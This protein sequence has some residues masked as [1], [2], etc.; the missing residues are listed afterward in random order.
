L[1]PDLEQCLDRVRHDL[2]LSTLVRLHG[3]LHRIIYGE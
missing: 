2:L 3:A 1:A